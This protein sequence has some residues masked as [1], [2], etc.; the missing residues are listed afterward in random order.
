MVDDELDITQ[1]VSAEPETP[2]LVVSS[3]QQTR[4][5]RS[6]VQPVDSLQATQVR[7]SYFTTL[8]PFWSNPKFVYHSQLY[9]VKISALLCLFV[10][11]IIYKVVAD[12]L[13][14]TQVVSAEPK[15]PTLV[16]SSRQSLRTRTARSSVQ[17]V[18]PLEVE[19]TQVR[20]QIFK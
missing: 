14:A 19:A 11:P 15:T 17:P 18:D 20:R 6:S 8:S 2:T 10:Q 3:R 7:R 4:T 9:S 1:V 13:D 16:V 12:D 5:P